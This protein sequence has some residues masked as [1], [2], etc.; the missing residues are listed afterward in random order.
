VDIATSDDNFSNLVTALSRESLETANESVLSGE[1]PFTVFA[2]I[3]DAFPAQLN[4]LGV[5]S[6]DDIDDATLSAVPEMHVI[7]SK[8]MSVD[9][10]TGLTVTMLYGEDIE[11]D[12]ENGV[13]LMG[14]KV[15]KIK[16]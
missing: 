1:G 5:A 11:F 14:H 13:E 8:V 7:T 9:L 4:E 16:Y 10:S 6:L 15:H 2:P 3:N 12:L